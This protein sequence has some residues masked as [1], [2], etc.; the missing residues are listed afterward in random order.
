MKCDADIRKDLSIKILIS[1]G[2]SLYNGFEDRLQKELSALE[3]IS[4]NMETSA[5]LDRKNMV[6]MGG[7]LLASHSSFQQMWIC[8]EEYDDFGPSIVHKNV[9][10]E[11]NK[12]DNS[13]IKRAI[14]FIFCLT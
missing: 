13:A 8:K 12:I 1:G 2:N 5:P 7:S 6:W 14:L 4:M 3:P 10:D 11:I 9:S